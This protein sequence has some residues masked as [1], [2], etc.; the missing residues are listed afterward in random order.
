M[1]GFNDYVWEDDTLD[2]RR[3]HGLGYLRLGVPRLHLRPNN[4]SCRRMRAV[5][6]GRQ[7]LP[8][9]MSEQEREYALRTTNFLN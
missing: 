1:S 3:T 7:E 9:E 6:S 4:V 2:A 8:S 5:Q